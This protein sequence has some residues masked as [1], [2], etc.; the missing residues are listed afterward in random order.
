MTHR[1][2]VRAYQ[3][4]AAL[5]RLVRGSA[6]LESAARGREASPLDWK[7][8]PLTAAETLQLERQGCACGDWTRVRVHEGFDP[9]AVRESTFEG[10]VL[11]ARFSGTVMLPGHVSLATGIRRAHVRDSVIGNCCIHDVGLV[12]RQIVHDAATL[13]RV[14]SLVASGTSGFATGHVVRVGLESS[15]RAIPIFAEM[16]LELAT[17]L[18]EHPG[19]SPEREAFEEAL[20]QHVEAVRHRVGVV[21]EGASILNTDTV[22]N[23]WI[24]PHA[25]IDG[26]Q[27]VRDAAILSSIDAPSMVRDG[28]MVEHAVLQQG[29]HA[30]SHAI[31]RSAL[32]LERSGVSRHAKL[33]QAV[34]GANTEVQ[35]GEVTSSLL[36]P[37]VGFHHQ[38]LLIAALWPEGRG[39][40][41][42]GAAIGSNHTGRTADQEI[43]PGEGQFF[44]LSC[45]VKF[46]AN[47]QDAPWTLV[48]SGTQVPPGR[49]SLPFSLVRNQPGDDK[50]LASPGWM[51]LHNAWALERAEAKLR[52]R[53]RTRSR[54]CDRPFL[55]ENLL[56]QVEQAREAL[57]NSP[58][59]KTVG[60]ESLPEAGMCRVSEADRNAGV[61]AYT[62]CL[63]LAALRAFLA[64]D[65]SPIARWAREFLAREF[66]GQ[67]PQT[68][69]AHLPGLERLWVRRVRKSR[70]RDGARGRTVFDDYDQVHPDERDDEVIKSASARAREAA[71]AVK[72]RLA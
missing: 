54:V 13:F 70:E 68:L 33:T 55:H 28:A 72:I 31:V 18:A 49:F 16:D 57:L 66:P 62:E 63:R 4:A 10:D 51:W 60:A 30:R 19:P 3:P 27:L 11:L 5:R 41:G 29:T 15:G 8:R 52:D 61:D 47:F 9:A 71:R 21:G 40:V 48:A 44:G 25:R 37:L 32:L 59:W 67:E 1:P 64:G 17:W 23:A 43:R 42:H 6:L 56:R 24:G 14:G 58:A 38:S 36:G 53:D 39:N 22:R 45:L 34:L 7:V 2:P 69:L 12:V 20:A 46:P 50:P 35:E 65:P 26:A